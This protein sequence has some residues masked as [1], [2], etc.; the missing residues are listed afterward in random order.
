[1]LEDGRVVEVGS[2]T[3]LLAVGGK[4]AELWARQVMLH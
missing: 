2:H 1:M 3:Q 4:Y